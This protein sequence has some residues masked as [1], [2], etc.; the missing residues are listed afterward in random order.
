[1]IDTTT[2]KDLAEKIEWVGFRN[3]S[4]RE[5]AEVGERLPEVCRFLPRRFSLA[6]WKFYGREVPESL[7]TRSSEESL[8]C[9]ARRD[10][11]RQFVDAL[12]ADAEPLG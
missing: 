9:F 5:R 1:M 2:A 12:M 3:L 8:E 6:L 7:E 10:E 11:A 4:R